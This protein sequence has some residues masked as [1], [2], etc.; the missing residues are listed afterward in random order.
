MS[1]WNILDINPNDPKT[2]SS[3]FDIA[4]R[5]TTLTRSE[6]IKILDPKKLI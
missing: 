5:M 6:L 3:I 4:E 1:A 2:N